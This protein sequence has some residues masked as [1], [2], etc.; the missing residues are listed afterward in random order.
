MADSKPQHTLDHL[1]FIK[2]GV[3]Y[4]QKEESSVYDDASQIPYDRLSDMCGDDFSWGYLFECPLKETAILYFCALGLIPL[5]QERLNHGME[6]NQ[7]MMDV[8]SQT[9]KHTNDIFEEAFAG[10][11]EKPS[12]E[13][14]KAVRFGL[15]N[16]FEFSDLFA[17]TYAL[18]G[19]V[20]ALRKFGKDMSQLVDDARNGVDE[21]FF[22]AVRIDSTV[23]ACAPFVKRMSIA[24]MQG[25]S[26]FFGLL[27]N[28]LKVKWKKPKSDLDTLRVILH[29]LN[30][31]GQ[32]DKLSEKDADALLIKN[33]RVY[34]DD[35]EDPARSLYRFI[36]R[37]KHNK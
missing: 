36:Q 10:Y 14:L 9:E 11:G 17:L 32:L 34:S 37:W 4:I 12:I 6:I 26:K 24:K 30:D 31:S 8:A 19:H 5:L 18:L 1:K 27:G 33:L 16:L 20:S 13:E 22:H 15:G 29:G 21:S 28:A 23:L 2:D 25:D 7:A 35:G 3:A